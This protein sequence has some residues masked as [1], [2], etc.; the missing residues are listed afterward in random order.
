VTRRECQ[1]A[2]ICLRER[3]LQFKSGS[4]TSEEHIT[5]APWRTS[6]SGV[7]MTHI[8]ALPTGVILKDECGGC[9]STDRM[10]V[11]A[12]IVA[13]ATSLSI[14]RQNSFLQRKQELSADDSR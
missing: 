3:P 6:D 8:V 12:L 11:G 9:Y 4:D 2:T 5:A 7:G 13:V 10:R 14:N 1:A